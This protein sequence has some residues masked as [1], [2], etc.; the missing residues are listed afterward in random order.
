MSGD[1]PQRDDFE[2]ELRSQAQRFDMMPSDM[3]WQNIHQELHPPSNFKKPLIWA[4]TL[5]VLAGAGSGLYYHDHFAS[6][7]AHRS[8]ALRTGGA[9]AT[10]RYSSA[11]LP[12]AGGISYPSGKAP[13]SKYSAT[14]VTVQQIHMHLAGTHVLASLNR[15]SNMGN[16]LDVPG[17]VSPDE[18]RSQEAIRPLP[19][20]AYL[21]A[22]QGLSAIIDTVD[23]NQGAVLAEVLTRPRFSFKNFLKHP[24]QW[25]FFVVPS[26]NFR[27]LSLPASSGVSYFYYMQSPFLVSPAVLSSSNVS[28]NSLSQYSELGFAAGVHIRRSLTARLSIVSGLEVDRFG[29]GIEAVPVSPTLVLQSSSSSGTGGSSF[30]NSSYAVPPGPIYNIDLSKMVSISN[31][32]YYLSLPVLVNYMMPIHGTRLKLNFSGGVDIGYLVYDQSNILSAD[33]K[34]YYSDNSLIRRWEP[35]LNASIYFSIPFTRGT[36]FQLGP[37]MRYQPLSTYMGYDVREHPYS[38]GI[39]LGLSKR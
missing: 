7:S 29:Y 3:V 16:G 26:L 6:R 22:P 19:S 25:D 23:M 24:L 33:T 30:F 36:Y 8:Y 14:A 4:V 2:R 34:V 15:A 37:E 39:R 28:K 11:P 12:A 20:V 10:S 5:L 27:W 38:L 17:S 35:D 32:Y 13:I 1:L 31:T 9:R 18:I 21:G